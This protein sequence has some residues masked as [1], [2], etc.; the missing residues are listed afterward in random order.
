MSSFPGEQGPMWRCEDC[1]YASRYKTNVREHVE[2]QHITSSGINCSYCEKIC[3][4]KKS[5]RN[6]IYSKHRQSYQ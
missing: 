5:L 1:G 4:N 3:P 6:H 2:S